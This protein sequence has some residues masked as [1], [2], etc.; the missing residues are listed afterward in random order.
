MAGD[1]N[2][3]MVDASGD[4]RFLGIVDEMIEKDAKATSASRPKR[5][6]DFV[7]VVGAVKKFDNDAFD[8]KIVSPYFFHEFRVVHA[9]HK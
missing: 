5:P 2:I 1:K 8:A 9:F 6:H 7:Q 3:G 4:S